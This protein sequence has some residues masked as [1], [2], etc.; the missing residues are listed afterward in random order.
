M[1]KSKKLNVSFLPL[2][3]SLTILIG[4]MAM[5]L[6]ACSDVPSTV[7][8]TSSAAESTVAAKITFDTCSGSNVLTEEIGKDGTIAMPANPT[9]KSDYTFMGW[10][11]DK[12]YTTEFVNSGLSADATVYAKWT[13]AGK[14]VRT[15]LLDL[16]EVTE[17][18]SNPEEG[19]AWDAASRTLTLS[20]FTLDIAQLDV[21]G[22][23]VGL[24]L[25]KC[26]N[27]P[28]ID[29]APRHKHTPDCPTNTLILTDG[30]VNTVD[31]SRT[32]NEY[33]SAPVYSG[34]ALT[35]KSADSGTPGK[36]NVTAAAQSKDISIA[37][38]SHGDFTLESGDV[39]AIAGKSIDDISVGIQAALGNLYIKS[40]TVTAT[41]GTCESMSATKAA[42]GSFGLKADEIQIDGGT[43]TATGGAAKDSL[44]SGIL[45]AQ[46]L[47]LN[48]GNIT[49][50]GDTAA[51]VSFETLTVEGITVNGT[52]ANITQAKDV[53]PNK[54]VLHTFVDNKAAI[55]K[56]VSIQPL[57]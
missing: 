54:N 51:V 36:L 3:L 42:F 48:G 53:D 28:N 9:W 35:I 6:T 32:T 31:V 17:D 45:G 2:S 23:S 13:T 55:I 56:E 7:Q 5:T 34:N 41:G 22:S 57:T 1:M 24:V 30:T 52:T 39:S 40:G 27:D 16:Y 49:A 21:D 29:G 20:D 14:T 50:K 37:I 11:S 8:T 26:P 47:R 19:W 4:L 10:Y 15:Q 33:Y 12:D 25:P 44:S 46:S 38:Y 43:V 18:I